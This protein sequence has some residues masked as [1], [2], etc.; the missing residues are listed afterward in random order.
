MTIGGNI[1]TIRK[2]KGLTQKGLGELCGIAESNIRKYENGRQNPKLQTLA[3]IA[4][5]LDVN[6]NDLLESPLYDLP[7]YNAFKT[8]GSLNDN[9]AHNSINMKLTEGIDWKPIDI[10]MVKIFKKLN[11]IGQTKAVE[12]VQE[13]AEIPRYT[14]KENHLPDK[15]E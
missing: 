5:A 10:E 8:S 4:A 12:R 3:K 9:L 15:E 11:K 6:V 13:L 7:I 1:K 2:E 14:Q